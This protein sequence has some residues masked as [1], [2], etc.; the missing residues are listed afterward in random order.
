MDSENLKCLEAVKIYGI[1]PHTLLA[2]INKK[3]LINKIEFDLEYLING[4][5]SFNN[6][7]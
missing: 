2:R 5:S 1:S 7:L 3:I 4:L 6:I